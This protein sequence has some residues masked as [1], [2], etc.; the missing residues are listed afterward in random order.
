MA[1]AKENP[2]RPEPIN[3]YKLFACRDKQIQVVKEY[4][5]YCKYENPSFYNFLILGNEGSGKTSMLNM[6]KVLAKDKKIMIVNVPLF[7]VESPISFL[8]Q[9]FDS[10]MTAGADEDLFGGKYGKIYK[11]F[12]QMLDNV[13]IKFEVNIPFNFFNV[14]LASKQGNDPNIS[15]PALITD[16]KNIMDEAKK[17]ELTS[18]ALFLDDCD[19]LMDSKRIIPTM[20]SLF[21]NLKGYHLVFAGTKDLKEALKGFKPLMTLELGDLTCITELEEFMLKPLD[22]DQRKLVDQSVFERIFKLAHEHASPSL[23]TLFAH[24]IYKD[25]YKNL[26]QENKSDAKME[27]TDQVLEDVL[28]Q[29]ETQ[30]IDK[31]SGAD[32]KN[33]INQ[34]LYWA[35]PKYLKDGGV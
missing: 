30:C 2:Y 11:Q 26:D 16:F 21:M 31:E 25:Y 35:M 12:R 4:L 17:Q 24:Y 19:I 10:I 5:D 29:L 23:V 22:E 32:V 15:P 28:S 33:L 20:N 34:Y 18:I 27:I 13:D 3:E 1:N 8:K 7:D 6:I 9:L 14:Y